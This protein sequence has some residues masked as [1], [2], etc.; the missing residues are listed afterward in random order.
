MKKLCC[1]LL[2]VLLLL[3]VAAGCIAEEKDYKALYADRIGYVVDNFASWAKDNNISEYLKP[4]EEPVTVTMVHNYNTST[5]NMMGKLGEHYGENYNNNRWTEIIKQCLNIDVQ[6]DW[7]THDNDYDTK[8]RMSMAANTL[9]D[10]F[11]VNSLSDVAQ[12]AE[13]GQILPLDDLIKANTLPEILD[14]WYMDNG[15][16]LSMVTIDGKIYGYPQTLSHTDD[17]GYIFIRSDW[18]KELGIEEPKTIEDVWDIGYK[19]VEAGKAKYGVYLE[20]GQPSVMYDYLCGMFEAYH[21][22]PETWVKTEDGKLQFGATQEQM[23]APLRQLQKMY[24]DGMI[25]PEFATKDELQAYE[26]II[27]G[28]IG[29]VF[30]PHWVMTFVM[31]M[32]DL[33]PDVTWYSCAVP[34]SDGKIV[35]QAIKTN[36]RGFVCINANCKNPE[37][38]FKMLN[39]YHYASYYSDDP[40]WW[41][42]E[43]SYSRMIAPVW[44]T[45]KPTDNLETYENLQEVFAAND[46]SLLKGKAVSYYGNITSSEYKKAWAWNQ[47][48]GTADYTPMKVLKYLSDNGLLFYNAYVG[49]PSITYQDFWSTMNDLTT[50]MIIKIILGADVDTTFDEYVKQ[51]NAIGGATITQEAN[52]WFEAHR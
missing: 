9:P 8:L 2:T 51:W 27:N 7:W 24:A 26:E 16:T 49:A 34:D 52:E 25:D 17:V 46:P 33:Q 19:F 23:K 22:Y 44:S 39:L 29:L 37:A 4:Y 21:A 28:N 43:E 36:N 50:Q 31:S 11:V 32:Y 3:N 13:A 30:G 48:F 41:G 18:M 1:T 12:L 47:M 6:Y 45:V 38:A 15:L 42:Y 5:E 35:P 20:A 10:V 14:R 40:T